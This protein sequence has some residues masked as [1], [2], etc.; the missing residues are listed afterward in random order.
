MPTLHAA[1]EA[2]TERV[3]VANEAEA[4]RTRVIAAEHMC[5]AAAAECTATA[6][7]ERALFAVAEVKC[8]A[9]TTRRPRPSVVRG[10]GSRS[11]CWAALRRLVPWWLEAAARG[12]AGRG[13]A[14]ALRTA[15]A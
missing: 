6:Y 14:A 3:H 10:Y 2:R 9:E 7:A 13:R 12:A 8:A 15:I 5:V 4:E 1:A 11:S